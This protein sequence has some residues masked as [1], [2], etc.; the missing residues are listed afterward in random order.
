MVLIFVYYAIMAGV[1]IFGKQI[2]LYAD[3]LFLTGVRITAGGLCFLGYQYFKDKSQ[4]Y[5]KPESIR[6][7]ITLGVILCIMD[8]FRFEALRFIPASNGALVATTAPFFAAFLT[9]WWFNETFSFKRLAALCIGVVGM[10]PLLLSHLV[11]CNSS[12]MYHVAMAYAMM[13]CATGGFVLSGVLSKT[14]INR[15]GNAFSMIVGTAMTIAGTLGFVLSLIFETWNPVPIFDWEPAIKLIIYLFFTHSL[16]AYG[17]YNYLVQ[18]YPITLVAFAQ[19]T[20]PIFSALFGFIIYG[21]GVNI[22][23]FISLVLL[24]CA[25]VLFYSETSVTRKIT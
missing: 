6:Y 9:W 7:V 22:Q 23:F 15:Q 2:I 17:L 19:L 1:F 16:L 5:I 20:V 21:H 11:N 3:P 8:S 14:L 24:T 4:F 25:M 13:L 12:D 10:F 18:R